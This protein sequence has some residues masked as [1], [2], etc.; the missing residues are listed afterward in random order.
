MACLDDNQVNA[1]VEGLLSPAE[2]AAIEAHVDS[3]SACRKMVASLAAAR[4][5]SPASVAIGP[6]ARLLH[7]EILRK[8]GRGGMGEVYAARDTKLGREVALKLLPAEL[9]DD[10]ER[11]SRLEREARAAAGLKSP[12]IVTLYAVEE[13]QGR[14][15]ISMELVEGPP[16]SALIA[17]HTVLVG[18]LDLPSVHSVTEGE[19]SAEAPR[20]ALPV[21]PGLGLL[22]LGQSSHD[23]SAPRSVAGVGSRQPGPPGDRALVSSCSSPPRPAA[24]RVS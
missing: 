18:R 9:A 23:P 16:L 19:G 22:C 24:T 5:V 4:S 15:F 8:L 21:V 11:R 3:C 20:A 6:G 10:P 2:A 1:F 13:D 7:Y 12:H 14:L 17:Q